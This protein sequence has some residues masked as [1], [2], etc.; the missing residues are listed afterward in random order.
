MGRLGADRPRAG[1]LLPLW[2]LVNRRFPRTVDKRLIVGIRT[3]SDR[4]CLPESARWHGK[5]GT[6]LCY[7]KGFESVLNGPLLPGRQPRRRNP[8]PHRRLLHQSRP[9]PPLRNNPTHPP[10]H[11]LP[12]LPPTRWRGL[13]LL[14]P[15]PSPARRRPPTHNEARSATSLLLRCAEARDPDQ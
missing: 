12:L 3:R 8:R 15:S 14:N 9:S 13:R 4:A 10:M 2:R 1:R 11:P 7:P 5:T 6:M